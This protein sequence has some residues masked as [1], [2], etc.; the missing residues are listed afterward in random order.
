[1]APGYQDATGTLAQFSSPYGIAVDSAGVV[2]VADTNN[3]RI[4][5]IQQTGEV[6]TVVGAAS[7]YAEGTGTAALYNA[8]RGL[9]VSNNGKVYIADTNNHRIRKVE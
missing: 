3:N 6:T 8:P 4:R 7:G 1:M 2:Y 9:S 5:K